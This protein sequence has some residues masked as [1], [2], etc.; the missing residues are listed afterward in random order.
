[1]PWK[2][3]RKSTDSR[4]HLAYIGVFRMIVSGETES[5]GEEAFIKYFIL[6]PVAEFVYR[7][8]EN[9]ESLSGRPV[10][11]PTFKSRTSM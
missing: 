8:Y 9:Q 3:K 1:V 2:R 4:D 7:S 6:H 11:W 5:T 10:S